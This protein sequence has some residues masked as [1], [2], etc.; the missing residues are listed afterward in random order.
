GKT[1]PQMLAI[2][3]ALSS[4]GIEA[5][6]GGSAI[7]KLMKIME[8]AVQSYDS[9]NSIIEKTGKPLRDLE[10]KGSNNSTGFKDLA[11]S[12]GLTKTELKTAMENV[13]Q[14]NQFAQV[15]GQSADEFIK[16][17]GVDSVK[18]LGSFIDGLQDTERTGGNAVT[19]LQD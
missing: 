19:M 8:V 18:A 12:L 2:A 9:S 5:E 6:A 1:E 13:K 7:S 17:Y 11:A 16:A 10:L 4:V 14:L 15:S 3:T